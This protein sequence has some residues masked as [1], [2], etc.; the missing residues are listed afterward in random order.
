[1]FTHIPSVPEHGGV[2]VAVLDV[3]Q[4]L[5]VVAQTAS[6]ALVY[7]TGP[8]YSAEADSGSRIVVP[9][10]RAT[11][12]RRLDGIIVSHADNDHA[13]GTASVFDAMPVRWMASSLPEDHPLHVWPEQSMRCFAGQ[14]WV[15]DGVRFEVLHPHWASYEVVRMKSNDRSCVLRITAHGV[16]LL[17]AG[18]AEARSEREMLAR[19]AS[20]LSADILVVPHHG[21]T[22]SSTPE[23]IAAVGPQFAVFTSG[24]RNRFGHPRPE[25]LQR[26]IDAGSRLLR[27][28]RHGAVQFDVRADGVGVRI[29]R[30]VRRRY[31]LDPP[32]P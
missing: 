26:Y 27:S 3:G 28:D 12:V 8:M 22:T 11:G 2:R 21:S 24:Y 20:R 30:E 10:L 19:D 25:V 7:D 16:R 13:G 15:W 4:G 18:D 5:S 1:M 9:F 29:E 23:F 32:D 14:A 17:I 31:W 6:H